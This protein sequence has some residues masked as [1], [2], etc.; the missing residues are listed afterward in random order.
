MIKAHDGHFIFDQDFNAIHEDPEYH[1]QGM[2]C[3]LEDRN[4]TDRYEAMAHGWDCALEKVVEELPEYIEV[5]P[6]TIGQ[7]VGKNL[8]GV[9]VYEG[10]VVRR[11]LGEEE[12]IVTWHKESL[13]FRLIPENC[14]V[15]QHPIFIQVCHVIRTIYDNLEPVEAP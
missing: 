11:N 14:Y 12:Y 13:S 5:D 15:W 7:Y 2:G 6:D 1:E 3:G 10:D 9:S 4:I 8:D